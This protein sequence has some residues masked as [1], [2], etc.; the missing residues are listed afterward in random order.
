M[1]GR[2]YRAQNIFLLALFHSKAI[3]F[4]RLVFKNSDKIKCVTT[5]EK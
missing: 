5:I 3:N 4:A 1:F 2:N